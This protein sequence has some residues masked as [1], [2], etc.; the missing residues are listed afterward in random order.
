M[1][2]LEAIREAKLAVVT[3]AAVTAQAVAN[4]PSDD[5]YITLDGQ[6]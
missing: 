6:S 1:E 5:D 2:S 3:P 4:T